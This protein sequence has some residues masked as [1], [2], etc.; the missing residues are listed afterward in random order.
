MNDRQTGDRLIRYSTAAVVVAVA[1]VAAYVSYM[2]AYS[3]ARTYGQETA[4]TAHMLPLT[5]DGMI[6]ASS[7]VMLHCARHALQV[8]ALA[9]WTLVLG[10]AATLAANVAHGTASGPEG[11]VIAAWPAV[12]LVFSYE[13]LMWLVRSRPA[14]AA[15]TAAEPE[16]STETA[17]EP[18][19]FPVTEPAI[20][21]MAASDRTADDRP[22]E[23]GHVLTGADTEAAALQALTA[24][25]DMTGTALARAL[26]VSDRTGRRLR[27]RLGGHVNGHPERVMTA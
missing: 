8:P 10:I 20:P 26:G 22:H 19:T 11:A 6:F 24:D 13:L 5:V 18:D 16:E 7:M 21:A 12:A 15:E 17:P 27:N 4:I 23:T 3:V 2:H 25:P 1:G 14:P 9:R